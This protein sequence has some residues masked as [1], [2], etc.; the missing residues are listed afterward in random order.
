MLEIKSDTITLNGKL[1]ACLEYLSNLNNFENLFPKD[2]IKDW[3]SDKDFCIFNLQNA[4]TLEIIKDNVDKNSVNL[5]SGAKSP[6]SFSIKI[7]IEEKDPQICC[8]QIIC[9]AKVSPMLKVMIGKPLNELFNFMA[10][11]IEEAIKLV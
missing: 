11:K 3:K 7:E 1:E 9:K 4:Y 10:K 5:I 6:F 2:K 8:G